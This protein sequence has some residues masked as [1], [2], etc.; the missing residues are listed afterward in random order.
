MR[1]FKRA[2]LPPSDNQLKSS[3]SDISDIEKIS[4]SSSN[5]NN[6]KELFVNRKPKIDFET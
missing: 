2:F 3:G 5:S 6:D 4:Q 1:R